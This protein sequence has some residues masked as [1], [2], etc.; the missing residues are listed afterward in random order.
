MDQK[1][2][3]TEDQNGLL[4]EDLLVPSPHDDIQAA[5]HALGVIEDLDTAL[6][7]EEDRSYVQGI[8]RMALL[9]TY[10]ALWEIF[11]ANFYNNSK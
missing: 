7:S 2:G 8:R 5:N 11:D 6:L 1:E 3:L 10:Q 9:I 4:D